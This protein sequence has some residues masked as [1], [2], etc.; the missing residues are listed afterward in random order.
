VGPPLIT[1]DSS[2]IYSLIDSRERAHAQVSATLVADPGPYLVPAGILAETAYLVQ[3]RL[4]PRAIVGFLDDLAERRFVLD[5]GEADFP[6]IRALVE[7][8]D[9]LPLGF[10]DA[11][12]VACAERS[13]GRVLTLDIRDFGVVAR[14]GTISI[15]PE[16]L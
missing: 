8:Y 7:R 15:L 14:E 12:V 3:A 6:R 2:A 9:D 13:G 4:G 16:P 5:C 1:L 11:A 10:S